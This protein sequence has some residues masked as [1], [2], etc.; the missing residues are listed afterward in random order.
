MSGGTWVT[1][2]K[3]RPGTYINTLAQQ[4]SQVTG[5]S[6]IVA[7]PLDLDWGIEQ[8]VI[9]VNKDSD[10]LTLFGIEL[11]EFLPARE[12][13]KRAVKLYLYRLNSNTG[14]KAT[15]TTGN[16]VATAKYSGTRGND[17]DIV[18]ISEGGGNFTV[19]TYL[20]TTLV[21]SQSAK[22]NAD[23]L[24]DNY[25]VTFSG[26]GVLAATAGVSLATGTT[27]AVVAGNHTSFRTAVEP[28]I[29]NTVALYDIT[30]GTTK[31]GYKTWI[32]ELRDNQ[33]NKVQL[34]TENYLTADYEGVISV[35]NGVVLADGTT[36]PADRA[37]AWVAGATAAAQSN[38]SLT[39]DTYDNAVDVDTR[40]T[41]AQI[42]SAIEAG[43]FLFVGRDSKA[44]VEVDI[45]TLV[46]FT[47][48][49]TSDFSKNRVLRALDYLNNDIINIGESQVIGKLSNNSDGRNLYKTMIINYI[50]GKVAD[51]TF[52]NFDSTNDL[53]ILAG[54]AI[55]SVVVNLA[56][57]PVDAIEK[58][59]CTILVD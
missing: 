58:V 30:D 25:F 3:V 6:G 21:D 36:I 11:N 44:R 1:Q 51:G 59:Y 16:L 29:W 15:V 8:T 13:L 10:F 17:I 53:E 41:N 2:N 27:E 46:T 39:Y 12:A 23:D 49:K 26:T 22:A 24:D 4:T 5:R 56:V 43:E 40:Y 50:D 28:L 20:G 35:K 19:E 52:E 45:N 38:Q 32:E 33:G 9:E 18:I 34:I 54:D 31:D 57:Q 37:T 42:I 14:T 47:D 55:D 7:I 48:T